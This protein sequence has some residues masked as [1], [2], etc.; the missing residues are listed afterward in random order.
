MMYALSVPDQLEAF[1]SIDV[2]A[3]VNQLGCQIRQRELSLGQLQQQSQREL[4]AAP[5]CMK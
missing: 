5:Y 1:S 4:I 2:L 3:N